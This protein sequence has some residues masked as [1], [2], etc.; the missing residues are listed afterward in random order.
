[1]LVGVAR[2]LSFHPARG[3]WAIIAFNLD[4]Y[5][6]VINNLFSFKSEFGLD[7]NFVAHNTAS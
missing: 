3:P 2:D 1:M 5:L 4:I 6:S 7:T